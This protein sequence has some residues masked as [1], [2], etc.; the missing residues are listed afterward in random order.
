MPSAAS[1]AHVFIP[2][3]DVRHGL[4]PALDVATPEERATQQ[5]DPVHSSQ[6]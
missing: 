3:H 6:D 4:G 2:A 1:Q 5:A